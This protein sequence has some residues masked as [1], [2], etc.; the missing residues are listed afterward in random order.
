M[1]ADWYV[2]PDSVMAD[3]Q[4]R[5][6]GYGLYTANP[7][8]VNEQAPTFPPTSLKYQ[9]YEYIAPGS[10]EPQEGLG[11]GD[12][13]MLLYLQMTDN[14][15]FPSAAI[16]PYT[17]NFVADRMDGT[18]C[19]ERK[20]FLDN[21]L[22]RQSAPQLLQSLNGATYAWVKSTNQTNSLNV[23]FTIGLGDSGHSKDF[24]LWKPDGTSAPFNWSWNPDEAEQ[25]YYNE[26]TGDDGNSLQIACQLSFASIYNFGN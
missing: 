17:G 4:K 7:G 9:T 23:Q 16:L 22:L 25:R 12:N 5:T 1:L 18:M 13:N 8:S 3:R 11:K 20:I 10:N 14:Q 21:Y 15:P 19:V 24:F 2:G 6:V 26:H